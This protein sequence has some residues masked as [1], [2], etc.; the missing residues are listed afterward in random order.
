MLAE[1]NK[2]QEDEKLKMLAETKRKKEEAERLQIV[3]KTLLFY[4]H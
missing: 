4:R 3:A 2:K 1:T